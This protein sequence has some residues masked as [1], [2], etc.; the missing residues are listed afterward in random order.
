MARVGRFQVMATLQAA[1]AAAL[2]LDADAARSWGLNR[3]IFYAAAKRGF[4]NAPLPGVKPPRGA[5]EQPR[6]GPGRAEHEDPEYSLGNEKAF[7]AH[8]PERGLLC[9]FGDEVQTPRDFEWQVERRFAD[10]PAAWQ[11]A[12]ELIESAEP[13]DL[14]SQHRFYEHVYKP[15]RDKLAARWAAQPVATQGRA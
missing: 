3:A 13:G 10:W 8:P 5:K 4:R 2:G 6:E 9:K 14:Q 15:N 11:E 12:L 7:L 1:R